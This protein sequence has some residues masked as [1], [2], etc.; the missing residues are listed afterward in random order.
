MG[1]RLTN[2]GRYY[3]DPRM[4]HILSIKG[5]SQDVTT[6][7][8]SRT[9]RFLP[10]ILVYVLEMLLGIGSGQRR[11]SACDVMLPFRDLIDIEGY[12]H[13]HC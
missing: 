1:I 7:G 9:W 4:D 10:I 5:A 13:Q 6:G 12:M 8:S 2:Q 11:G 3:A